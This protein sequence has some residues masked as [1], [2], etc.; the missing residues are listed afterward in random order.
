MISDK[1]DVEIKS[2]ILN[3]SQ[4]WWLEVI[5][6]R[7]FRFVQVA[8]R[9]TGRDF[10]NVWIGQRHWK[11]YRGNSILC[12]MTI[13]FTPRGTRFHFCR[14]FRFLTQQC[15]YI[16]CTWQALGQILSRVL[17]CGLISYH[18]TSMST[19]VTKKKTILKCQ[20]RNEKPFW[21]LAGIETIKKP[22]QESKTKY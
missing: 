10:E 2:N 8:R 1:I 12:R 9:H 4:G 3:C 6:S 19:V 13:K 22:P 18:Q 5:R 15:Q 17:E 7:R 21:I 20:T 14:H 16:F 11:R